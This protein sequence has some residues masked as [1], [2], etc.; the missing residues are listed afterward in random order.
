[1]WPFRLKKIQNKIQFL[2]NF[3]S[4]SLSQWLKSAPLTTHLRSFLRTSPKHLRRSPSI[5]TFSLHSPSL[6]T[7]SLCSPSLL[8]FWPSVSSLSRPSHYTFF[9]IDNLDWTFSLSLV[10]LSHS[11][12]VHC[13]SLALRVLIFWFCLVWLNFVFV[14][15]V[16]ILSVSLL[17]F[18]LSRFVKFNLG[19]YVSFHR[20]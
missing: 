2:R 11:L 4:S 12:Q 13:I 3:S 17:S 15:F 16:W 19:V 8:T 18:N 6:L 10:G 20:L 7:F 9:T 5:L 1:V 14:R